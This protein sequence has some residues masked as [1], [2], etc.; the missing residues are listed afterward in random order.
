MNDTP[1]ARAKVEREAKVILR[2]MERYFGHEKF[3]ELVQEIGKGRKGNKPDET[4][5]ALIVA[6]WDLAQANGGMTRK[7]FSRELGKKHP[8]QYR[9]Q[10]SGAVLQ[11]LAAV[12]GPAAT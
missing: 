6:E 2:E 7:K 5:N 11:R 4:L 3:T 8:G 10:N 1:Q 9:L 12:A